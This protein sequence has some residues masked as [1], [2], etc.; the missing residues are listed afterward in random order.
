MKPVEFWP[1]LLSASTYWILLAIYASGKAILKA[2]Q[3]NPSMER[4]MKQENFIV[5]IGN[6]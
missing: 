3:A 6:I 1:S 4:K 5:F 2:K